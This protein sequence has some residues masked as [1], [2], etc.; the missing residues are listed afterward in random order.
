LIATIAVDIN[1]NRINIEHM[2]TIDRCFYEQIDMFIGC[3]I[4]RMQSMENCHRPGTINIT[5]YNDIELVKANVTMKGINRSKTTIDNNELSTIE[6]RQCYMSR[7]NE[8]SLSIEDYETQDLI[9]LDKF[10][11]TM[12]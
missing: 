3:Y 5:G 1:A 6:Q 4:E 8:M 7:R 9:S 11:W 10:Q 12:D 2:R